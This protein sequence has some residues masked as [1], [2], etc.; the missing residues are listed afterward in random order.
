MVD[1]FLSPRSRLNR[2]RGWT[3][4]KNSAM[5]FGPKQGHISSMIARIGFLLIGRLVLLIDNDCSNIVQGSK[6][7]RT[8]SYNDLCLT[9]PNLTP[10]VKFFTIWQAWMHDCYQVTKTGDETIGHL[11]RQRNFWNQDNGSF[12]HSQGS[13]NKMQV[14]LSLTWPRHSFQQ[15]RLPTMTNLTCH[16]FNSMCLLSIK[17]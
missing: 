8:C 1:P 6:D 3:K 10:L 14:N 11:W 9:R 2:R 16:Y 5:A 17:L 7:S 4:Y 15:E 12:S 13:L